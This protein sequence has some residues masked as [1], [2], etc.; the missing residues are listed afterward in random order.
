MSL[1]RHSALAACTIAL[2]ATAC[3]DSTAPRT[4]EQER[5]A[6][7][8]VPVPVTP[9]GPTPSPNPSPTPSPTPTPPP[10][11]SPANS[12]LGRPD[13]AGPT[14]AWAS[15][16]TSVVAYDLTSRRVRGLRWPAQG[17]AAGGGTPRVRI[18]GS[19]IV[20]RVGESGYAWY[21]IERDS[22]ARFVATTAVGGTAAKPTNAYVG[23]GFTL[24]AA[25]L[26]AGDTELA[27]REYD[28]E[29][30]STSLVARLP[31]TAD[32][33]AIGASDAAIAFFVPAQ[34]GKPKSFAVFNRATRAIT[35]LTLTAEATTDF[36]FS[37]DHLAYVGVKDGRRDLYLYDLRTNTEKR[38]TPAGAVDPTTPDITGGRLIWADKRNGNYDLFM[39][40]I[41]SGAEE[42]LTSDGA[43]DLFPSATGG[44]RLVWVR[45]TSASAGQLW[46]LELR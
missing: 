14:V 43:D 32:G 11:S 13:I 30:G 24:V 40:T 9:P 10:G 1:T 29:S 27:I 26:L 17:A 7:P 3:R 5:G 21:H 22:V 25:D 18:E 42:R 39:Y 16:D 2:L 37:G 23:N 41:A 8:E 33:T 19:I 35:R 36:V 31:A 6:Q 20:W 28:L 38:V 45:S 34:D 46:S 12:V 4:P 15:S 44:T